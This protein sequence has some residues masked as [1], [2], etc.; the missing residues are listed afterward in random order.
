MHV[1]LLSEHAQTVLAFADLVEICIPL[2]NMD[3]TKQYIMYTVYYAVLCLLQNILANS[4]EHEDNRKI[5][6]ESRGSK[7]S[8]LYCCLT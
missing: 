4:S 6:I 7:E 3:H 5:K 2:L 8:I 1:F